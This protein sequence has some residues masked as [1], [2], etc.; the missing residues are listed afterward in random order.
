M[1]LGIALSIAASI[2][3]GI[4]IVLQ[5]YGLKKIKKFSVK[6]FIYSKTWLLGIL[7]GMGGII[8]YIIA[9]SLADLSTVQPVTALTL[10]IPVIAGV[11]LFKE[12]VGRFEWILLCLVI[13]GIILVS[14]S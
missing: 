12:K 8:V 9:L 1:V 13:F 11:F 14:L 2:L 3:F 4:S 6:N 5:K 10:I 7:I